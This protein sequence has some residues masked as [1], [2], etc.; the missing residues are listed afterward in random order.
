MDGTGQT[1]AAI[2]VRVTQII[3]IALAMSC[4]AFLAVAIVLRTGDDAKPKPEMPMLT[5][6]A[7]GVAAMCIIGRFVVPSVVVVSGRRAIVRE[8]AAANET[9]KTTASSDPPADSVSRLYTL[10]QAKT[11]VA[12]ALLEGPAFLAIVAYWIEGSV[13]GLVVAGVLI[14]GILL[15]F[16]QRTS[17]EHWI[18]EQ[19]HELSRER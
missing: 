16:P 3:T 11:I 9:A 18:E 12:G 2:Q 19:W 1:N 14:V 7:I 13:V 17:V 10:F 8:T 15:G 6:A 4:A 5:Y